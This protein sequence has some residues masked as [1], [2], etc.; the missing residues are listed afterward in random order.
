MSPPL[1]ITEDT[2]PDMLAG[3]M[4]LRVVLPGGHS[5]KMSVERSTPM[6][7]LLVQV[8]TT[9]KISPGGHVIQAL[10]ERGVLP[11]K[12]STPIGALD[13]WTI[14]IVP[15]HQMSQ[16]S[17]KK[18]PLKSV[19]QPFEQTFRLQVHLPRNQLYVARV[20]P[21][22][23]LS[24]ILMQVCSEKN[25]D[26]S[27]YSLRHP[28]N[29]DQVLNLSCTLADYKLQEVTLVYNRSLPVEVSTV[30]IMALQR[31]TAV[32]AYNNFTLPRNNR[33]CEGSVSSGSLGGRSLSPVH[34]DESSASPP[35]PPPSRP[36]R[37]RRPAPKPPTINDKQMNGGDKIQMNE[38]QTVGQTATVICHSRNSSDS[39]GYHEASVLSESPQ[40]NSLPDSLPR[41]SKLPSVS[42]VELTQ[43]A[44]EV[45]NNLSRSLSNL[46]AVSNT[47]Q[48]TNMR[49]YNHSTSAI[50]LSTIGGRKKKAAPP[51]P[52]LAAT[53]KMSSVNEEDQKLQQQR[54]ASVSSITSSTT[55][56]SGS[57]SNSTRKSATLPRLSSTSSSTSTATNPETPPVQTVPPPNVTVDTVGSVVENPTQ[58]PVDSIPAPKPRPRSFIT[59]DRT[60][61]DEDAAAASS[62]I[63]ETS[64][65]SSSSTKMVKSKKQYKAPLPKPRSILKQT[66]SL[67][68]II[69]EPRPTVEHLQ[70]FV[71]APDEIKE[72]PK[73]GES[74]NADIFVEN[75]QS[76]KASEFIDQKEEPK[77][78][79]ETTTPDKNNDIVEQR[80]QDN[81]TSGMKLPDK[82]EESFVQPEN[83]ENPKEL[84]TEESKEIGDP[85]TPSEFITP[86]KQAD[87][88]MSI[89]KSHKACFE[90]LAEK[91]GKT[92]VPESKKLED[93]EDA[94][95]SSDDTITNSQENIDSMSLTSST[96]S[97]A[98]KSERS[99]EKVL[100]KTT[101]S[102]QDLLSKKD[103]SSSSKTSFERNFSVACIED[104][105][106][107]LTTSEIGGQLDRWRNVECLTGSVGD[108]RHSEE[109]TT[110]AWVLGSQSGSLADSINGDN[111]SELRMADEEIDRIFHNATRDHTS[112]ESGVGEEPPLSLL[113][114]PSPPASLT[115]KDLD[116]SSLNPDPMDWEYKLPAPPTFRDETS[117]PTVTQFDTVTIGNLTEVF[118]PQ[119]I[120]ETENSLRNTVKK[121]GVQQGTVKQEVKGNIKTD[122]SITKDNEKLVVEIKKDNETDYIN[123][124]SETVQHS[125]KTKKVE[126]VGKATETVTEKKAVI[127]ELSTVI[128]ERLNK[129]E[130]DVETQMKKSSTLERTEK[131]ATRTLENFTITTY[132]DNKK[133][134]EVF[135]DDS[136]KS[137]AGEKRDTSKDDAAFRAP[138]PRVAEPSLTRTCS[139]SVDD[140]PV[141][142]TVK[143][144]ISYV[145]LLAAN[146]PRNSQPYKAHL[147]KS[148]TTL[149]E[150]VDEDSYRRHDD[151]WPRLRKTTSEVNISRD[152][153]SHREQRHL[154]E[155]IASWQIGHDSETS[156]LQSLQVLRSILPQLS[157]SH[158][159][160]NLA[161]TTS[162]D[163]F[164]QERVASN[165]N[166]K[167]ERKLLAENERGHSLPLKYERT[168]SED[169]VDHEVVKGKFIERSCSEDQEA[170]GKSVRYVYSG[171][172]T[173]NLS[174][175]NE[176]PKRQVS[177]KNDKDYVFGVGK[178]SAEEQTTVT[179]SPS[180]IPEAKKKETPK[181]T[182]PSANITMRLV[183]KNNNVKVESV[184]PKSVDLS[185]VPIVR[186]V[187]LKKPYAG[188]GMAAGFLQTG[189]SYETISRPDDKYKNEVNKTSQ[190]E[191]T[192]F[193]GVNSIAKKFG[194][195]SSKPT[196]PVSCYLFGAETQITKQAEENKEKTTN[197]GT[198]KVLLN[199]T[200]TTGGSS[201]KK[202]TSIVGINGPETKVEIKT[203]NEKV[204]S[205]VMI[206][207]ERKMKNGVLPNK[208]EY[209]SSDVRALSKLSSGGFVDPDSPIESSTVHPLSSQRRHSSSS[210]TGSTPRTPNDSSPTV[211]TLNA[212]ANSLTDSSKALNNNTGPKVVSS[213]SS[214]SST[215]SP[216]TTT[217]TNAFFSSNTIERSVNVRPSNFPLPVV[218]GFRS[219]SVDSSSEI[220]CGIPP[221]PPIMPIFKSTNTAKRPIK[222]LPPPQ[223]D[224]RDKL[225]ES[226][227]AFGKDSLRKVAK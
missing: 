217:K 55:T 183:S 72:T 83:K 119:S 148:N 205:K 121:E 141:Q 115:Q 200:T 73:L 224:P 159:T 25:L 90:E 27:R 197:S 134:I 160:V 203:T 14:H 176:R 198:S 3:S 186:S 93:F 135:E 161:G 99:A 139:F 9:N 10:G 145:S 143:R 98:F 218:K 192:A 137:S 63:S 202:F 102:E 104:A 62:D 11:Y 222:Q 128:T 75:K 37:K 189:K 67:E 87:S 150:K 36:I 158:G 136:I 191:T 174:T 24:D 167:F 165:S 81:G 21:K 227:R 225:L 18:A 184:R 154:S 61:R 8:T 171:P 122:N 34:S 1:P 190:G 95:T 149:S 207:E 129:P 85:E 201:S 12:P 30:D 172:P 132:K 26:P 118:G 107:I 116:Q 6:M 209:K 68:N 125:S 42:T 60:V 187:E 82:L 57:D 88:I 46:T 96:S 69:S 226:I 44:C 113:S 193:T 43:S 41:R 170:S 133:P 103:S 100:L 196:R 178:R 127:N 211:V 47:V 52:P 31:D 166:L 38:S 114:L 13:T 152:S 79:N 194:Q 213:S 54:T 109:K 123:L 33:S 140:K 219:L 94:S 92:K 175:W 177:I 20:S 185:H 45:S 126:N 97:V 112:L 124:K 53:T 56:L 155:K 77:T 223:A 48:Q 199:S 156:G 16:S 117:S 40:S 51:P 206:N 110:T 147:A 66:K 15:K 22:A 105:N 2:P 138:K 17:N 146:M 59:I 120:L 7:D 78:T 76:D 86:K 108:N 212:Q 71:S 180:P 28:N 195:P 163:T 216:S 74:E 23:V 142:P 181:Q 215:P 188:S 70:R 32:S 179:Q 162:R 35:P 49:Q 106:N 111:N 50:S 4:D 220:S 173:I 84:T 64:V 221:P 182:E 214:S 169:I 168:Q 130:V 157:H 101:V 91:F 19:N 89:E 65:S 153:E 151:V 80:E 58:P 164:E 131:M 208:V 204:S 29:L 39:S 210:S 5:V 144:S